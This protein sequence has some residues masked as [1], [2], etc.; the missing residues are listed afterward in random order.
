MKFLYEVNE[1][2]Q[3]YTHSEIA[4]N[5]LFPSANYEESELYTL[6]S[7]WNF[8]LLYNL[9]NTVKFLLYTFLE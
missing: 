4:H 6:T 5:I 1:M 2:I 3:E 9:E 8:P 7:Y